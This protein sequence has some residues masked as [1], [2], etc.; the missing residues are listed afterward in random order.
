MTYK[1]IIENNCKLYPHNGWWPKYAFHYTDVTNAIGI[2]EQQ[3]LYSRY[4]AKDK[5]LMV[6]DNASRQVIDMTFSGA[7]ADV[8]F[9]F[10]PLTPTQYHNEGFKHIN[11]RYDRDENA[12]VPVPVF[13]CFDLERM[14]ENGEVEFSEMSLA[15][16]GSSVLS[17]IQSFA[18]LNFAEIYKD[19]RMDNPELEKKYRQAEIIHRGPFPI[20]EYLV[21]IICRNEPERQTLLNLLRNESNK[22]FSKYKS[23]IR[24]NQSCFENNAFYIED[25][26][27]N[28]G[29]ITIF[30]SNTYKKYRYL[31][32]Y[33]RDNE[34]LLVKGR[35][36]IDYMKSSTLINREGC[37]IL[38]DYE[39][40][41]QIVFDNLNIPKGA[42][43]V[44]MKVFFEEKLMCYMCW[45]L[46]DAALL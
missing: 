2:L 24:V 5:S 36:E 16:A 22:L 44:H 41:G 31:E 9:Y 26:I 3:C 8:R 19:G 28:D 11:I 4:D 43:S 40:G 21:G 35:V 27:Y 6:N 34:A 12:N 33:K 30:L 15:G 45:Q 10:R 18:Q 25:C 29:R 7:T 14:L 32:K 46:A 38:L 13:F 17:G 39:N 37:N 1:E 20:E 42:T 23:M